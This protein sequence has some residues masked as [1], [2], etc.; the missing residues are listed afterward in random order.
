MKVEFFKGFLRIGAAGKVAAASWAVTEF[1]MMGIVEEEP[2]RAIDRLSAEAVVGSDS[3]TSMELPGLFRPQVEHIVRSILWG[4]YLDKHG[5]KDGGCAVL[6][7]LVNEALQRARQTALE[8]GL[9]WIEHQ[10]G[11]EGA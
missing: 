2:R 1:G 6:Y 7:I 5:V 4:G 10:G 3:I 8:E 11:D 9:E